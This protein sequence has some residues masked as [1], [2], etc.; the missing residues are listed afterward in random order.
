VSQERKVAMVTGGSRGIGRAVC[1][2]LAREY[3]VVVFNHFDPDETEARRTLELLAEAGVEARGEKFDV[4]DPAQVGE[5]VGRAVEDFGRLDALVNNA[6]ITRDALIMR[7]SPEQWD[8]V[9]KV[10]L[11]GA[12]VCLQAVAKVMVKQRS[13]CIVNM[14]SVSGLVGNVGQANYAASKAGLVGLTKTA[15]KEL[16]AR[17][18][19]VN[20]IAPGFIETEMTKAVPEKA[21]EAMKAMIP[22]GRSGQPEDVAEVAAFLCSDAARYLTG[23]VLNVSGGM[24]M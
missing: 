24:F 8:Q 18:V 21:A 6:G 4:A 3:Q 1:L 19:R 12:F 15:A 13:G 2:A 10:N 22:L 16:A 23:Q 14:A 9:I 5:F 7:M 17:G 20:A 11:T